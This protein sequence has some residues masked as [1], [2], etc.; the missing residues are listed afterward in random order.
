MPT[1]DTFDATRH[2]ISDEDL[3]ALASA[4]EMFRGHTAREQLLAV[5]IE[6]MDATG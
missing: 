6:R 3:A 1:D 5:G 4:E 2:L